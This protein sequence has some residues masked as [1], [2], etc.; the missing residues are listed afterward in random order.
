MHEV[1]LYTTDGEIVT[2]V[3]I[4]PF[5]PGHEPDVIMWGER[6]FKRTDFIGVGP[7]YREC[8]TIVA[9]TPDEWRI[10]FGKDKN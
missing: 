10:K 9:W 6:F 5:P 3:L 2:T 8:F 1:V 7:Q 4:P